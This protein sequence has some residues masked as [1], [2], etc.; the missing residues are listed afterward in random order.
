MLGSIDPAGSCIVL[1]LGAVPQIAPGV[2]GEGVEDTAG[3]R[4]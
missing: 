3:H 1:L 4:N 2:R